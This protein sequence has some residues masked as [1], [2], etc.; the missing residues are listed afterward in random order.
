MDLLDALGVG[1]L[2]SVWASGTKPLS[3]MRKGSGEGQQATLL[4]RGPGHEPLSAKELAPGLE[5]DAWQTINR[6]EGSNATLSSCF[7]RIRVCPAHRDNRRRRLRPEQWLL[8]EWPVEQKEPSKYW[9][10]NLDA[11]I[12]MEELMGTEKMRWRV[13]HVA[14]GGTD[15]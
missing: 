8:V 11:G 5:A 14:S 1:P 15:D 10:S 7:A 9:L 4:R 2:T 6:R 12:T 13:D 3:P